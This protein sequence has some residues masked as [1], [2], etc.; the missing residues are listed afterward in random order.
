MP[1]GICAGLTISQNHHIL[2]P[3]FS[4]QILSLHKT[5]LIDGRARTF[6]YMGIL[7]SAILLRMALVFALSPNDQE[8]NHLVD[9]GINLLSLVSQAM[10]ETAL[11]IT[12]GPWLSLISCNGRGCGASGSAT[13]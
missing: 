1:R 11:F 2:Y 4:S 12:L 7:D 9:A 10:Q 5:R 8:K 6:T 3:V 13:T